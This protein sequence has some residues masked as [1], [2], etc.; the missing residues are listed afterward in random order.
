MMVVMG[1]KST[2]GAQRFTPFSGGSWAWSPTG[3]RVSAPR[4]DRKGGAVT[5]LRNGV[6]LP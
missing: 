6:Q 3:H 1:S 4:P 5:P 2:N